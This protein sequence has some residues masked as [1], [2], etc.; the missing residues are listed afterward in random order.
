LACHVR[1]S[2]VGTEEKIL[3]L[4]GFRDFGNKGLRYKVGAAFLAHLHFHG[5]YR[6]LRKNLEKA[7]QADFMPQFGSVFRAGVHAGAAANALV[8]RIVE[9]SKPPLVF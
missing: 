8:M 1:L 5:P 6:L 7:L 3:V 9:D 2:A 4:K